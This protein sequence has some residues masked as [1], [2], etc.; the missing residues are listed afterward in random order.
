M[1]TEHRIEFEHDFNRE[2]VAILNEECFLKC[3][4]S[5]YILM[6]QN[7]LNLRSDIEVHCTSNLHTIIKRH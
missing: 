5:S 2:N 7:N 1:I 4:M 6:Q 3:L